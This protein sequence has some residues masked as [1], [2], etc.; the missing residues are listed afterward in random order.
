MRLP[1]LCFLIAGIMATAPPAQA[2][3]VLQSQPLVNVV[4]NDP[5]VPPPFPVA[6][7]F[8]TSIPLA[9]ALRQIVPPDVML[10]V[11]RG[12]DQRRLVSWRGGQPWNQVLLTLV[13]KLGLHAEITPVSVRLHR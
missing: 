12:V 7:G 3:F 11:G 8:G 4:Q 1:V 10:F 2:S 6:S 9:F 13:N 5:N